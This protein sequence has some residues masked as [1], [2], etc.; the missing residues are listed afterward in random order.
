[1]LA[2]SAAT[3][4]GGDMYN[5]FQPSL[6]EDELAAVRDVFA[7]NWPGHG[8]RT[9]AFEAEFAARLGVPADHV[10]FLNSAT[11][12]LFLA[13]ELLGLGP[14]DDV[15]LPSISCVAAAN[16][17]SASGARPVFCDVDPRTLNASVQDVRRAL[18]PRTRA[19]LIPHYGGH[20]GQIAEIA[21]LCRDAGILLIEDAAGAVASL[22]DGQPCGT[23]GDAA[24]WSFDAT[25]ILCTGDG[26]MLHVR[27][28]ELARRAHRLA[29]HGLRHV[30]GLAASA[31]V[32]HRWWEPVVTEFG[33][34]VVGNDLTAAI[35][36][37]QL[38]RLPEFVQ[39]RA[40]I[41]QTYDR[42]LTGVDCVVT[43]P[44]LPIGQTSS[45]WFYWVQL[46]AGIRDQVTADLLERNIYTTFRYAPLHRVAAYRSNADLPGA[47]DAAERTL[48][49]PIH[50]ALDD[51]ELRTIAGELCKSVEHR[52]WS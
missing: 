36:S 35:G 38:R 34:R 10:V 8:P 52:A 16:A 28:P 31:D 2:E 11:A 39:R 7:A 15:V 21:Q 37:V 4:W 51:T 9:R 6:G 45:H 26:G 33:R 30:S 29:Y 23:F 20:P 47:D 50:P 1:M 12:G 14:D 17:V 46:D 3:F 42:L 25:Q 19:V 18:T 49:L 5:V 13:V 43:P 27:D 32:P 41:A 22:V 48:L 40:E 44:E 24:V